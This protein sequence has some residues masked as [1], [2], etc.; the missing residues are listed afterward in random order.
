LTG[1]LECDGRGRSAKRT[2][3]KEVHMP[4]GSEAQRKEGKEAQGK[5]TN[6]RIVEY[7]NWRKEARQRFLM[8]GIR[9]GE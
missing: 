9:K 3:N 7:G 8:G 1:F 6:L 4:P 2:D 5:G